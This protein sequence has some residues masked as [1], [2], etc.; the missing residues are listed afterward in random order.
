MTARVDGVPWTAA[1]I[2]VGSQGAPG[3]A[4]TVSGS[5]VLA[6]N[7]PSSV[8]GIAFV[9]NSPGLGP[10]SLSVGAAQSGAL[11]LQMSEALVLRIWRASPANPGSDGT[12]MMTTFVP[13]RA[14]GTFSAT[15]VPTQG[16][17]T[18]IRSVTDGV[19]DVRF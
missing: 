10:F 4:F 13:G 15:V 6:G 7:P 3:P 19:F 8:T 17:A 5:G 9:I 14:V 11:T 18:G 1:A 2:T 16:G 12:V